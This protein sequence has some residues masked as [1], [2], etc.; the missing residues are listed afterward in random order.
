MTPEQQAHLQ[1]EMLKRQQ[2][3]QAAQAQLIQMQLRAQERQQ[4]IDATERVKYAI[5][6]ALDLDRGISKG[7]DIPW[8]YSDDLAWFKQV[9]SNHICVMGKTTYVDIN[10]RL[11]EAAKDSVLPNRKCFVVSS[12]LKQEDVPNA[13][14]I[15]QCYDV[16]NFLTEDD[17]GKTVFFIG[18]ERIYSESISMA[19]TVHITAIDKTFDCDKFFPVEYVDKYFV[20]DKMQKTQ[21]SPDLRFL[22]FIRKPK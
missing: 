6:V 15:K 21:S 4:M 19:D 3:Q 20:L 17:L 12:T 7:G 14:V 5:I 9:T 11:G 22:T 18:G 2:A 16:V 8:H 13:T 1:A 10:K